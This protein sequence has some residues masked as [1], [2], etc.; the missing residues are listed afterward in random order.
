MDVRCGIVS[1]LC[2]WVAL[3]Q[4]PQ[5]DPI[6]SLVGAYYQASSKGRADEAAARRADA[7]D[8]LKRASPDAPQLETWAGQVSSLYSQAGRVAEAR[9]VLEDAVAQAGNRRNVADL[10]NNLSSCWEQDGNLPRAVSYAEKALAAA[11]STPRPEA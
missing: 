6:Q 7:R 4:T 11:E 10:L 3:A 9:A 5:R 8:L 1:L 2:S